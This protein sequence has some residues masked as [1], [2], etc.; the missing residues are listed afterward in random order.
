MEISDN[1]IIVSVCMSAYNHQ[2][3]IEEALDSVLEQECDFEYEIILSNDKST[4]QTDAV[5]LNF[6]KSHPKSYRIKYYN[7]EK[8]LGIND[9]LIFTLEKATAKYIALL[10]GDDYW[11]DMHKLQKQYDFMESHSEYSICT[12][13]YESITP[14][15]GLI[16]RKLDKDITGKTYE[17]DKIQEFRPNY[18]NMFFRKS[19]LDV[20]KLKGFKYSGDNVIFLMCIAKGK[21]YFMNEIFG[22]R[23]THP[24][25][26]WTSR[27]PLERLEMGI[28]QY[29]GLYKYPEFRRL[30]RVPLF[31][32]SLDLLGL[33]KDWWKYVWQA[34][35]LIRRPKEL[36]YFTKT[37][38]NSST[39]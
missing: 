21:G 26:A 34:F 39:Q 20:Q 18:L 17:F 38:L 6:I 12:A 24:G 29:I 31:Y 11:V 36:L 37:V 10:E 8:N 33:G 16:T 23:R 19:S 7:Q 3:F 15:E 14:E 9:N 4:D 32:M 30:I 2:D 22:F 5:I 27:T 35:K 1:K 28:E 13:G 25:G